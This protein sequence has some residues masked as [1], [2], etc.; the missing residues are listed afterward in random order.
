MI[1]GT[2]R[3]IKKEADVEALGIHVPLTKIVYGIQSL[4][5]WNKSVTVPQRI[6]GAE[7]DDGS[8]WGFVR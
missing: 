5:L 6:I 3:S 8:G 1:V 7:P 4:R 2:K